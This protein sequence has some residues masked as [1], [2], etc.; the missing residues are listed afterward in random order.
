M[1]DP[2][3]SPE[4]QV[5]ALRESVAI[6]P[7]PVA[8]VLRVTGADRQSLLQRITS[9]ELAGIEENEVRKN[10]FISA[11]GKLIDRVS[12]LARPDSILVI[13]SPGRTDEIRSWL[14]KYAII[15]EVASEDVTAELQPWRLIGPTAGKAMETITGAPPP[16][17]GRAVSFG[18]DDS[19]IAIAI[20]GTADQPEYLILTPPSD[21]SAGEIAAAVAANGGAPVSR[22]AYD[23]Y[24]IERG[25]PRFGEEVTEN[26]H[27]LEAGYWDAVSFDKGC[28][29]GQEVLARLRNY[30]KV[31][32]YLCRLRADQPMEAGAVL[33]SGGKPV[34]EIRS[35]AAPPW[36]DAHLALGFVK[37]RIVQTD[38]EVRIGD[39]ENG[40]VVQVVDKV[41][42]TD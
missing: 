14:D 28:Y 35:A 13:A 32:R 21:T 11:K 3:P 20:D 42:I 39:P 40:A 29:V 2:N 38:G 24:R 9:G 1:L 30:D 4:T 16:A 22:E 31:M 34:G 41:N 26:E 10:H 37:R 23:A 15:E 18:P 6:A 17:R 8:D 36:A 19:R 25:F 12:M 7:G 5:R 33:Y 27:P